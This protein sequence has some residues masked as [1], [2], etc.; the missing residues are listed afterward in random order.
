[1]YWYYQRS[2]HALTVIPASNRHSR[3]SGNLN[4]G[5]PHLD[6]QQYVCQ[7]GDTKDIGDRVVTGVWIPAFAGMTEGERPNPNTAQDSLLTF[8]IGSEYT[9]LN[10]PY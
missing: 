10:F 5:V 3:E 2:I 4:P 1:M 9:S 8:Q 7:C 6:C